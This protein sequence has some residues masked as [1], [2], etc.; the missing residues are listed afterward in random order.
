MKPAIVLWVVIVAFFIGAR[1]GRWD[2]QH[3]AEV[4]YNWG[5]ATRD[6]VLGK[7]DEENP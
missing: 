6:F 3:G 1:F 7:D 2:A 5:K 4:G